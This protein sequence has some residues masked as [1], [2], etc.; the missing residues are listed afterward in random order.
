MFSASSHQ[1]KSAAN[2][3]QSGAHD[4]WFAMSFGEPNGNADRQ[5]GRKASIQ[6]SPDFY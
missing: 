4:P 3:Q 5:R 2:Q 1:P 6:T